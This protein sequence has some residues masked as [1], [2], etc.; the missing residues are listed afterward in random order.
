[1]LWLLN[2]PQ[3]AD[4]FE[5]S[6]SKASTLSPTPT[7]PKLAVNVVLYALLMLIAI[8][9]ARKD[10]QR[11]NSVPKFIALASVLRV[12]WFIAEYMGW[13]ES[14]NCKDAKGLVS[15]CGRLSSVLFFAAFS[16]VLFFWWDVLRTRHDGIIPDADKPSYCVEPRTADLLIKF[17]VFVVMAG[18]FLYKFFTC[19]DDKRENVAQAEILAIAFTFGLLAIGFAAV[20]SGLRIKLQ[21]RES[22]SSSHLRFRITIISVTCVVFFFVRATLFLLYPMFGIKLK[23]L[24][25]D[26]TYPWF[27]YTMP[28][29][30]PSLTLLALL[31]QRRKVSV[32]MEDALLVAPSEENLRIFHV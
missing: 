19:D 20:G 12:T 23:G 27:F 3:Y 2:V 22:N 31:I 6:P 7:A 30:I 32:A 28:E 16:S 26:V 5:G 9:T 29:I 4:L 14:A 21:Y 13:G 17:W 8:L 11:L 10:L 1:M 15:F 24:L 18:L 25:Q